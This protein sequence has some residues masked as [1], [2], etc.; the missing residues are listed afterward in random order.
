ML[1][2]R[3]IIRLLDV[4]ESTDGRD[5]YLVFDFYGWWQFRV[6]AHDVL[7]FANCFDT[8]DLELFLFS[9]RFA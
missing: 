2:H 4:I 5:L 3:N 7:F 1:S 9:N 8:P 6:V